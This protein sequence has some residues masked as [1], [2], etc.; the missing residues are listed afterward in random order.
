[1]SVDRPASP[2]PC[3]R[4]S[5]RHT[6]EVAVALQARGA[7][8]VGGLGGGRHAPRLA[9]AGLPDVC[10]RQCRRELRRSTSCR[11][12]WRL[13]RLA[14]RRRGVALL[15]AMHYGMEKPSQLATVELCRALRRRL[16]AIAPGLR[17]CSRPTPRGWPSTPSSAMSRRNASAVVQ[18]VTTRSLRLEQ[19]QLVEVVR[20]GHEPAEEAAQADAE[21]VGD[22]LVA[23]ERR[24]LAEHPVAV[25]LTSPRRFFASRRAWRSACCTSAGRA[26]PAWPRSAPPRSPRA[27]RRPSSPSTRRVDVTTTRPRSSSGRP[28]PS[29][30]RVRPHARRPDDCARHDPLAAG[31]RSGVR[32]DRL[33][34]RLG[35]DL[36]AAPGEQLRC[37]RRAAGDLREDLR[38]RRP[39]AASGAARRGASGS[40][41]GVADEVGELGERL[42]ARVAG[43]DEDEGQIAR[44]WPARP[45]PR[46]PP[47]AQDVLRSGSRRPASLKPSACSARPGIGSVARPRRARPRGARTDPERAPPR[48]RPDARRCSVERDDR[49]SSSSACGHIRRSGTTTW[50]GSSVPTPPP[51]GSACTA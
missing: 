20:P 34:C 6:Q 13:P 23:A 2:A 18:S 43:P 17:R 35:A 32:L 48:S 25:R 27:P 11:R 40:S 12:R 38:S 3:P 50:R 49:P 33:E 44:R 15:D 39:R 36:D 29:Q 19:R 24:H 22:A 42:H 47:V 1:M 4:L 31:E 7:E 26:V 5:G 37:V 51:G 45:M 21:H 30:H 46:P 9:D 16:A 10:H 28:S 8:L 41:A 14:D